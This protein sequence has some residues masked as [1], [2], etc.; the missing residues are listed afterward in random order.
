VPWQTIT[1]TVLGT[2]AMKCEYHPSAPLN[3]AARITG[4]QIKLL[5]TVKYDASGIDAYCSLGRE[6]FLDIVFGDKS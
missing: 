5:V 3:R 2:Q 1:A 6:E 4:G